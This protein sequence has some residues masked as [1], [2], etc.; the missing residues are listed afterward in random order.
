M[1]TPK[2]GSGYSERTAACE[3]AVVVSQWGALQ[4]APNFTPGTLVVGLGIGELLRST[5]DVE[6]LFHGR[7]QPEPDR[8]S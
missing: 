7:K 8:D 5:E 6:I 2:R 3:W 1:D 4:S